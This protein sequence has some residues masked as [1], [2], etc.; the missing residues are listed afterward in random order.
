[1]LERR[2]V[3]LE[4]RTTE[5]VTTCEELSEARSELSRR[6]QLAAAGQVAGVVAH[7]VRNPLGVMTNAVAL[8]RHPGTTAD[9]RDLLI[10]I[11]EE[12]THRLNKMVGD[13]LSLVEPLSPAREAVDVR[14]L[15]EH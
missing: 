4:R 15:V 2:S 8:L 14:E 11:I 7:E 5:L 9:H 6:E 10:G 1:A 13:L 3:E 12:E